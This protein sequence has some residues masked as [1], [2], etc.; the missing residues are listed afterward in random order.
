MWR[1]GIKCQKMSYFFL[2]HANAMVIGIYMHVINTK[3]NPD[4]CKKNQC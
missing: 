1:R 4:I 2:I 3:L